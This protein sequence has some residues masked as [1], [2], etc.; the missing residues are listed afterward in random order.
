MIPY[1]DKPKVHKLIIQ[2]AKTILYEEEALVDKD[3]INVFLKVPKAT[4]RLLS[5]L[6]KG[7]KINMQ[8]YILNLIEK[9]GHRSLERGQFTLRRKK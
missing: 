8:D 5:D 4:H 3:F 1:G 7:S 9:E 6:S 2:L